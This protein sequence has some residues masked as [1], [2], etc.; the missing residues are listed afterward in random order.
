M[1]NMKDIR[2]YTIAE[3]QEV[4]KEYSEPKF[5]AKQVFNWIHKGVESFEEMNNI[6][7]ALIEKLRNDFVINNVKILKCLTSMNDQTKK[8]LIEFYDGNIIECVYMEYKHGNT[9]CV[10]SQVG[11]RMGCTFC[12]SAIGGLTRNITAGEMV[13]QILAV[14]NRENV[15]ISNIVLMGSGE[16]LDNYENV[17]K[18]IKL[19]NHDKGLNISQRKITLSTCGI[20]PKIKMLADEQLQV[21]LA[22]S[23]HAS[24]NDVRSHTMPINKKYSIESLLDAC[25]YYIERTNRRIT[26]EYALINNVNDD[27]LQATKLGEML[28]GLLCHVNLI[29]INDVKEKE[30]FASNNKKI[31]RF[32]N[33]LKRYGVTTTIRRELGSDINAAC[34]QLRQKFIQE[35][36]GL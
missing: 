6:P 8:Y 14:Q 12:A 18:F 4:M 21:T 31:K 33:I 10:S 13:G 15:R 26:F 16:P 35:K 28:Q 29:P 32:M 27:E 30:Y 9:L 25:R 7:R 20:V 22:I 3:L 17:L 1:F 24:Q 19:V 11:C 34:G 2:S 23:L 36:K 5:R